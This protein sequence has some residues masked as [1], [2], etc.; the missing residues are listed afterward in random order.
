MN[1][2]ESLTRAMAEIEPIG[3]NKENK[4]QGFKYRGV[5]DVMNALQPIFVK[6]KIF[7]VPEVL[8]QTREERK[9]SKGGNLIYSIIKTKYTFYAE[10][11]T[12]VSAV[13]VGE[14]MDSADKASNKAMAIAFKYACFQIFCIPTEE[15]S[16][17]PDRESPDVLPPVLIC[18]KCGNPILPVKTRDGKIHS[19]EEVFQ[20]Y[21]MCSSCAKEEL[22]DA[23][24]DNSEV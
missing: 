24:K 5:D 8:E 16:P 14:G 15:T 3:K 4:Q 22:N 19:P 23:R 10:D 13:V 6:N 18:P 12:N 17:D 21:G 7:A 20:K 1:I 11:G 9:T 2:Y